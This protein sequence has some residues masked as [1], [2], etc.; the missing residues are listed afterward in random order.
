MLRLE[1]R[2]G[3]TLR[4]VLPQLAQL[5]IRVF[6]DWPYLYEG[7][8]DYEERYLAKFLNAPNHIAICAFDGDRLVGASTATPLMHQHDELTEPFRKA[9]HRL[10]E[11]FYFSES[12]LLP[13]Y[14]GRG[15]GH[16]FFDG[17]EGH[18]KSL[19]YQK[20]AFCAVMR[21]ADHPLLPYDYRPLDAFWRK[22]GYQ[23]LDGLVAQFSWLDIGENGE[24][25]KPM[26]Y[27]GRGFG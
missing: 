12:V 6:R 26:Q 9:S 16:A 1:N 13:S 25:L 24:S 14:R 3:E 17:R 7:A 10:D 23:P 11:I 21:P 22:R 18:A 27:W 5:R 20:T 8:L 15:V 2:S 19:G 4:V